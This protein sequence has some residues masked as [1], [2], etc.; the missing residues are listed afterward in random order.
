[1]CLKFRLSCDPAAGGELQV[2]RL[3][4]LQHMGMTLTAQ[5]LFLQAAL[6]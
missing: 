3:R 2:S 4:L 1:M 5:E 6:R